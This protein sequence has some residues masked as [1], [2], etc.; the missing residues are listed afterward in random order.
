MD[1]DGGLSCCLG[2][3]AEFEGVCGAIEGGPDVAEFGDYAEGASFE[4]VEVVAKFVGAVYELGDLG[5][6]CELDLAG[7]QVIVL[8]VD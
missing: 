3:E 2:L 8:D 7:H 4:F 6:D 5:F 1:A